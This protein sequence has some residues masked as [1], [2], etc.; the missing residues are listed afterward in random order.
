MA[1]SIVWTAKYYGAPVKQKDEKEN[2]GAFVATRIV[3]RVNWF[4]FILH[5]VAGSDCI[6]YW[7]HTHDEIFV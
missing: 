7:A 6:F 1:R 5:F 3:F 4:F 2:N